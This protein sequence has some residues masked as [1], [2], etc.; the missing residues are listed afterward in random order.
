MAQRHTH[1]CRLSDSR[2]A[3]N[4]GVFRF[5][6]ATRHVRR[7]CLPCRVN[8]T[9]ASRR[10]QRA[11]CCFRVKPRWNV[12][13]GVSMLAPSYMPLTQHSNTDCFATQ[14]SGDNTEQIGTVGSRLRWLGTTTGLP[15]PFGG[16]CGGWAN[17]CRSRPRDKGQK[18][19]VLKPPISIGQT[20]R[21]PA[22]N[23]AGV[24]HALTHLP[25]RR[26]RCD[27]GIVRG[28]NEACNIGERGCAP[29]AG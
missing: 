11:C 2:R 7:C 4:G 26:P 17:C 24:R 27:D 18:Q 25:A 1:R 3:A 13:S 5:C 23:A 14:A 21:R 9:R 19:R 20:S 10:I 8:F 12:Q 28:W 6:V 15:S 22:T 16:A 29:M